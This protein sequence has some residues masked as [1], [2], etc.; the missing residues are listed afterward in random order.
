MAGSCGFI[1]IMVKMMFGSRTPVS[2]TKTRVASPFPALRRVKALGGFLPPAGS[3]WGRHYVPPCDAP[4][5]STSRGLREQ[6][7]PKYF[8][9]RDRKKNQLRC[10]SPSICCPFVGNGY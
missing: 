1:M 9:R 2:S 5:P 8:E 10:T 3:G 6:R 4:S 7:L